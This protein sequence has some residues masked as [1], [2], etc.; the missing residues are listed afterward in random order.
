M[1]VELHEAFAAGAG[2]VDH[3]GA[4][5]DVEM[6]GDGLTGEAGAFGELRDG[7][8]LAAPQAA[9]QRQASFVAQRCEDGCARGRGFVHGHIT[10]EPLHRG[11]RLS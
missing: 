11:L 7:A 1:R 6:L 8:A 2:D 5:E 9:K 10:V 3:A 4:L